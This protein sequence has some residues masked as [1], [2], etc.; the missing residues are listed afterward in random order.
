[1]C[2]EI[3]QDHARRSGS[4]IAVHLKMFEIVLLND[5]MNAFEEDEE[6]RQLQE[7]N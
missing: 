2:C 4:L 1:M 5:K 7:R 3:W 6:R